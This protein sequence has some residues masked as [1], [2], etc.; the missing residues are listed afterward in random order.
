[1]ASDDIGSVT[2]CIR[3]LLK[4]EGDREAAARQLWTRYFAEVARLIRPYLSRRA[5]ADEEDAALSAFNSLCNGAAAGLFPHLTN[6]D[7]LWR[8]LGTIARRK[9]MK[10]VRRERTAKRGGGEVIEEA[11]LEVS[12]PSDIGTGLDELA[13]SR[14]PTPE[15]AA[16]VAEMW[17]Q[18]LGRLDERQR[19]V[20][21]ATFIEGMTAREIGA[22]LN[23]TRRWVMGQ[24]NRIRSIFR[25]LWD[26][27]F[28]DAVPSED[29]DAATAPAGTN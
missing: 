20:A 17:T 14:E 9:A 2:I 12:G 23:R 10:Q 1:M 11:A 18:L 28:S 15:F 29:P 4:P 13:I 16:M 27:D 22:E 5:A 21:I 6:R 7:D 25:E 3:E 19:R 24:L 8:L 26:A